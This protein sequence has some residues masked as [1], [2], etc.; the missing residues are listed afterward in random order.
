MSL[1][2]FIEAVSQAQREQNAFLKIAIYKQCGLREACV[3]QEG[4]IFLCYDRTPLSFL[5]DVG[6]DCK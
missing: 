5:G 1:L 3:L 6:R 4:F 2:A